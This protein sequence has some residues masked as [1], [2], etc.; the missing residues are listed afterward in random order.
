MECVLCGIASCDLPDS[1]EP[2][3]VFERGD[4]GQLRC[5]GCVEGN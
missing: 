4:D 1:V 5:Q 3:L 2:E